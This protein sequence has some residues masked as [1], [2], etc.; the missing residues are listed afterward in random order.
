MLAFLKQLDRASGQ[1]GLTLDPG[2]VAIAEVHHA[3]GG[4]KPVLAVCKLFDQSDEDALARAV[5]ALDNRRLPSVSLLPRS[6]YQMLL[7]EAPQV[8]QAELRAAVRWRIK[9][10]I[11]CHVDDAVIDVFQMPSQERSGTQQMMYAIAARAEEVKS[12]IGAVESSGLKLDAIDIVELALRNV[13]TALEGEDRGVALLYLADTAGFLLLVRHGVLY[14][15]RH[16]ETG[17]VTLRNA[18][19]LR[20]DIVAG[21]ALEIRRS[22]DYFESHYEQSAIRTLHTAGLE[23]SDREQVAGELGIAVREVAFASFLATADAYDAE[24]QRLCLP[25]VG[26]ALRHDTVAL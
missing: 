17:V 22:L 24:I 13:A 2:R 5:R 20:A 26:A 9:D 3:A 10:L 25:A 8:P 15:A 7:V 12:Q 23:P 1:I 16:I 11:D 18:A 6:S 14:L 19:G 21:L 4:G